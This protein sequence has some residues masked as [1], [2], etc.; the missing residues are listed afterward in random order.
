MP[1]GA[2]PALA[3]V[4]LG[5]CSL[6]LLGLIEQ[7]PE[8]DQK[9][10]LVSPLLQGGGPVATALVTLA[11]LGVATAVAGRIGGDD[12]GRSIRQGLEAEGVDTRA[13][14]VDP[15]GSSQFACIA[16]EPQQGTRNIFW[17]RG[18]A[19]A[20]T[21]A[22]IPTELIAGARLLHLDGPPAVAMSFMAAI[23]S[24]CCRVGIWPSGCAS[25]APALPSR[26]A[27]SAAERRF[28]VTPKS[29]PGWPSI[30]PQW[31]IP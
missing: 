27:P 20:L 9:T 1:P 15:G 3:V 28:P 29:W 12:F 7:F 5:Q 4:G 11:R 26:P 18:T 13:L 24:V 30:Q 2:P 10:E 21:P 22:E 17:T 31:L 8:A 16:V 25:P 14:L 19:A 23:C 6:D